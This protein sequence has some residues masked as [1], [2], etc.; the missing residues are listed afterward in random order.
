M[1][2]HPL[3][4]ADR[5]MEPFPEMSVPAS[6]PELWGAG[7]VSGMQGEGKRGLSMPLS[8]GLCRAH[9]TWRIKQPLLHL[10]HPP[11][12]RADIPLAPRGWLPQQ[13]CG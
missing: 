9:N 1:T 12:E 5:V 3:S 13:P 10:V 7:A 6:A 4:V 8:Q 11:W 2:L